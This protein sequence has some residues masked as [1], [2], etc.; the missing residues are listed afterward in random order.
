[1]LAFPLQLWDNPVGYEPVWVEQID[2]PDQLY[3]PNGYEMVPM[4]TSGSLWYNVPY[5]F[6]GFQLSYAYTCICNDH[7]SIDRTAHN[8]PSSLCVGLPYSFS[9]KRPSYLYVERYNVCL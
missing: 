1:M 8:R 5:Y 7:S 3:L 2:V 6:V 4:C 9:S